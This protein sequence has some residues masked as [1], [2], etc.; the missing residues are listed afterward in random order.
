[1]KPPPLQFAVCL[2][3]RRYF[4]I[5]GIFSCVKLLNAWFVPQMMDRHQHVTNICCFF[6]YIVFVWRLEIFGRLYCCGLVS[7]S[8]IFNY[9]ILYISNKLKIKVT[10]KRLSNA[11][12]VSTF[13]FST[14]VEILMVF[15]IGWMEKSC[16]LL[17]VHCSVYRDAEMTRVFFYSSVML[18]EH[19]AYFN[20]ILL[21]FSKIRRASAL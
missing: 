1:M 16:I 13:V 15:N 11:G 4:L 8:T 6:F 10:F 19:Y 12:S 5:R 7:L 21:W 2:Q 20:V 3:R 18:G 17:F 9:F 14:K